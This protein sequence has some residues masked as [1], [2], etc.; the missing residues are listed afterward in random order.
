MVEV[1]GENV[2]GKE[3]KRLGATLFLPYAYYFERDPM[4]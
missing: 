2:V 1:G 4:R 3:W